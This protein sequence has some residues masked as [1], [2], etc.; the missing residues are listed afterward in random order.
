MNFRSKIILKFVFLYNLIIIFLFSTVSK[1]ETINFPNNFKWCVATAAHQIEGNNINSDHYHWEISKPHRVISKNIVENPLANEILKNS[2]GAFASEPINC[3]IIK[4]NSDPDPLRKNT[5]LFPVEKKKKDNSLVSNFIEFGQESSG[6]V[7]TSQ[8]NMKNKHEVGGDEESFYICEYSGAAVDHWNRLKED[9]KL[10]KSL[11]VQWYRF[12]IEWAK[13]EPQKGV[14]DESAIQHYINEVKLLKDS[15]IEPHVTL[16]HFTMPQWLRQEGGWESYKS[17]QYFRKF[18]KKIYK[19]FAKQ[20]I[21]IPVWYTFN[22]PMVH[23]SAGYIAGVLPPGLKESSKFT[24]ALKNLLRAHA[25][26]YRELHFLASHKKYNQ[27]NIRVGI[28]H[29]LR[30]FEPL[31]NMFFAKRL[32]ADSVS[33]FIDYVW[34]WMFID[35]I[36]TGKLSLNTKYLSDLG[37]PVPHFLQTINY[38][39]TILK[40]TQD[41]L[42]LNYYSRDRVNINFDPLAPISLIVT[43]DAK[44]NDKITEMGWEIYPEGFYKILKSLDNRIQNFGNR[45]LAIIISESGIADSTDSKRILF[46]KEHLQNMNKAIDEGVNIEGFC[47]WSLLDNFEW[48]SGYYPQF[49]LYSVDLKNNYKRTLRNSGVFFSQV[50]K[51]NSFEK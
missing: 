42:G 10:I 8:N 33:F 49:G 39:D 19:E 40:G 35:A 12:S 30:V 34:N 9:V 5:I 3:S 37:I 24:I 17:P 50:S 36:E 21:Y 51:N 41:F 23:L 29:H 43:P 46:L 7:N 16:F 47:Y 32:I 13:V 48:N 22:E 6:S 15:G 28:A 38:E 11:N 25:L 4:K 31:D 14:Y 27:N 44:I 20:N 18:T 2:S 1:S 26:S 45:K